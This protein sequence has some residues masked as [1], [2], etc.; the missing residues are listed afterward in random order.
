VRSADTHGARGRLPA[1]WTD[2]LFRAI[3]AVLATLLALMLVLVLGNVI[4][5][6]GFGT[7]IN[8]SEELSRLMFIWVVFVGAVVAARERTHLSVDLLDKMLPRR[9]RWV[10]AMLGEAVVM[11]CCIL[12][13]WGTAL[14]HDIIA[15]TRS[16][17]VQYPMSLLYGVAYL[18]GGGM[19]ILSLAR[20]L[21][22]VRE[23]ADSPAL[24]QADS[25]QEAAKEA[26]G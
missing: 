18:S 16:L 1:T 13:V 26:A 5:R 3:E 24:R 17:L 21:L 6:Y 10:M 7:G 9:G 14:Q 15:T 4:L 11:T 20:I 22:L 12:V 2:R 8:V 23:G 25:M 19:A